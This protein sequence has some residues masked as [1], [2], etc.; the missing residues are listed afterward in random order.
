MVSRLHNRIAGFLYSVVRTV[1]GVLVACHGGAVLVGIQVPG[2][3]EPYGWWAAVI[4][5]V[6]GLLVAVGLFTRA[7]AVVCL[8]AVAPQFSSV[9]VLVALFGAGPGSVDAWWLPRRQSFALSHN[10][11][12]NRL[13]TAAH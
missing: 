13:T 1:L 5:I 9:F 6:A 8:G 12:Q 10:L 3:D 11:S 4:E 2:F 7:A